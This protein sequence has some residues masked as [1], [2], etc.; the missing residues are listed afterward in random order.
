MCEADD[1]R[2]WL[3]PDGAQTEEKAEEKVTTLDYVFV[4]GTLLQGEPNHRLLQSSYFKGKGTTKDMFVMFGASF[5]LAR[6]PT[7][8]DNW[9]YCG[10]VVGEVYG[11]TKGTLSALDRLEGHPHF[12]ERRLTPVIEYPNTE[13]WMYHWARSYGVI[14][15]EHVLPDTVTKLLSWRRHLTTQERAVV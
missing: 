8:T 11:V 2:Y 10:N 6:H 13:I 5:P 12:Y 7:E 15:D 3:G 1:Y 14:E 9:F 4:Y